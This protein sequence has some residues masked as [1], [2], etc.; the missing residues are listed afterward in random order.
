[1]MAGIQGI[2]YISGIMEQLITAM[3]SILQD[4]CNSLPNVVSARAALLCWQR[5]LSF[6]ELGALL[7]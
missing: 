1:M 6:E 3:D 7:S 2:G 4:P 5:M